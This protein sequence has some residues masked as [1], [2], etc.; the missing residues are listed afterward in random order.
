MPPNFKLIGIWMDFWSTMTRITDMRGGL[1]GQGH[2]AA[3][4]GCPSHHLQRAGHIVTGP[5]QAAQ[6]VAPNLSRHV[7]FSC[8]LKTTSYCAQ[9]FSIR[10]ESLLQGYWH[11][12]AD[13]RHGNPHPR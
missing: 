3:V 1:K 13:E 10:R 7:R 6:L 8:F 12:R 4:G 11:Q 5:L 9:T 2:Q